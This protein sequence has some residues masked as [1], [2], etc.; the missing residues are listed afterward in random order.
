M[1]CCGQRRA[2]LSHAEKGIE[3]RSPAYGLT[4]GRGPVPAIAAGVPV[5]YVGTIAVRVRGPVTGRAYEFSA[6]RPLLQMHPGDAD[7]VLRAP[8]FRLPA[9]PADQW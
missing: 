7:A 4:P 2:A 3:R 1:G 6:G 9:P 8:S 5:E